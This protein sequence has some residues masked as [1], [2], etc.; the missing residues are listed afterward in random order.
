MSAR[1]STGGAGMGG[2]G[3]AWMRCCVRGALLRLADHY[4]RSQQEDIYCRRVFFAAAAF[5]AF[6]PAATFAFF[7]PPLFLAALRLRAPRR[8][9]FSPGSAGIISHASPAVAERRFVAPSSCRCN[10]PITRP[11]DSADRSS[12]DS[13]SRDRSRRFLEGSAL[14][15]LA[16]QAPFVGRLPSALDLA[17]SAPSEFDPKIAE[18][19]N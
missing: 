1:C 12:S 15:C 13:S 8:V 11:S 18:L 9:A 5:F 19:L 3:W 17:S 6:V 2:I 14:F 16:I 4:A 7:A 10:A